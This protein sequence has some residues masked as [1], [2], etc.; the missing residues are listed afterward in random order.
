MKKLFKIFFTTFLFLIVTT[1][2]AYA[3]DLDVDCN[4]SGSCTTSTSSP[5]FD[6][7]TIWY[8]G[9]VVTK[10]INLKNSDSV[11]HDLAIQASRVSTI[12]ILE[13]VLQVSIFPTG[14]GPV[15]WSGSMAEFYAQEKIILGVFVPGTNLN[16]FIAISMDNSAGN[17]YQNI[18]TI[19]DLIAGFWATGSGGGSGGGTVLGAGVSSAPCSDPAPGSAPTLVSAIS[20]ANSVTLNWTAATNP[21]SYYLVAY[22][23]SPGVYTYGNP[24]VGGS[25][26]TSY[27]VNNLSGGTTYYFVVRAGNGCTPGPFSNELS[28]TPGGGIVIGPATGF[29][30][31]VLGDSTSIE[32]TPAGE[33]IG[34]ETVEPIIAKSVCWWWLILSIAAFIV[35][36]FV[37]K[38]FRFW[39]IL[40][41]VVGLLAWIGDTYIA[42]KYFTPSIWCEWMWL[43]SLLAVGIPSIF[44]IY[45]QNKSN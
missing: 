11:T 40:P 34:E 4:G 36:I 24:N 1:T 19:F 10:T 45:K 27:T 22:G 28:A 41:I 26:T 21:V 5:L 25:G 35:I 32:S 39:W 20:G 38:K 6:P 7:S 14:G 18:T 8:P 15:I 3:A 2:T 37:N 12:N 9:R 29:T 44:Y 42:H 17:E 23:T 43:W 13:D 33:V 16:Y 31:G 30:E